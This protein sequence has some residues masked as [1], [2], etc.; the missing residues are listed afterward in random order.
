[1]T[2]SFTPRRWLLLPIETKVRE[3]DGKVLLA[4][5]AAARGYG[6]VLG[7]K[8]AIGLNAEWLPKGV[9]L[10][11]SI[12]PAAANQLYR[13]RELGFRCT[14][15]DEE[16]VVHLSDARFLQQR[17]ARSTVAATDL[18]FAWGEHQAETIRNKFP[19]HADRV[20]VTGNPRVDLWRR[21]YR[22]VYADEVRA[23]QD[24]HGPYLLI[25]SNFA[26]CNHYEGPEGLLKLLRL[27]GVIENTE[28]RDFY[29]AYT[30]HYREIF[31]HFTGMLSVLSHAFRNHTIVVRPHPSED[32]KA[33]DEAAAGLNNVR[34]IFDGPITPW[35]LG[36]DA[37]IH[38]G[39][40]SGLEAFIMDVPVVAYRPLVADS[41]DL[42]L[43]NAVSNNT[44]SEGELLEALSLAIEG[45]LNA[46]PASADQAAKVASR[47]ITAMSGPFASD[48]L[49]S[50]LEG[51]DQPVRAFV[52][53]ARF[54]RV[55]ARHGKR[56][57]RVGLHLLAGR[58]L[59]HLVGA[60]RAERWNRQ[61]YLQQKMPGISLDEVESAVSRL[62]VA[63]DRFKS[64]RVRGIGDDLF[65]IHS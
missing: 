54:R 40:T 29:E 25:S 24:K 37:V 15:L 53:R 31:E 35:L 62:Q 63:T 7:S 19:E 47:Y 33:W 8:A 6:V 13:L 52:P 60:T 61:D 3:L 20:F 26:I 49:V 38:N 58:Y 28:D 11:K 30:A 48:R 39:C 51:L 32:R 5:H 65:V 34:I 16:G 22:G 18:I 10:L 57:L 43:P 56:W 41:Y 9:I 23:I 2:A 12:Q 55:M 1:M 21:E 44:Y 64:V 17:F 36:A 42:Y 45:A 46:L 4:S 14:S 50:A 27:D 59:P